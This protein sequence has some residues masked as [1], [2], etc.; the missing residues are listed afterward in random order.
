[1]IPTYVFGWPSG[2]ETGDFLAVD[3]GTSLSILSPLV[4]ISFFSFSPH[5][6]PQL[7]P[8]HKPPS[9]LMPYNLH[10]PQAELTSASAS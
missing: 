8:I 3:L 6:I 9:N 10:N 4:L 2:K 1:M 7:K 5:F